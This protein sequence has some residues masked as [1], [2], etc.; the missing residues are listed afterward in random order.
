VPITSVMT[1]S[2]ITSSVTTSLGMTDADTRGGLFQM[3][4]LLFDFGNA[5]GRWPQY[6]RRPHSSANCSEATC[7][8]QRCAAAE[9]PPLFGARWRR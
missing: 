4:V 7:D 9:P 6:Y 2:V 3:N 8:R 1:S 5:C